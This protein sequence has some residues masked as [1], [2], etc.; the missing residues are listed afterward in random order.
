MKFG[1][2]HFVL[3]LI[4]VVLGWLLFTDGC[5]GH[6]GSGV[7]TSSHVVYLPADSLE[8]DTV[9]IL[10]T[11]EIIKTVY[12][13]DAAAGRRLAEKYDSL[14]A[15]LVLG[16]DARAAYLMDSIRLHLLDSVGRLR[17]YVETAGDSNITITVN[18]SVLGEMLS[19]S[20]AW[21]NH[22]KLQTPINKRILSV[23]FLAGQDTMFSPSVLYIDKKRRSFT[24]GYDVLGRGVVA[25]IHWPVWK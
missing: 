23:G 2:S 25:G 7:D 5:C 9:K 18:T 24:F 4:I 6:E 22:R 13:K 8:P 3:I 14:T 21:Q 1:I 10:T 16:F 17:N 11:N 15:V 19:Q 20:I 12:R